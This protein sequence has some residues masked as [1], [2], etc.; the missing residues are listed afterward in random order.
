MRLFHRY[1]NGHIVDWHYDQLPQVLPT[2]LF[3]G[4]GPQ[5]Y[6]AHTLGILL[7]FKTGL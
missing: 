2:E 5:S 3:L 6:S 4:A 1:D 7:Q